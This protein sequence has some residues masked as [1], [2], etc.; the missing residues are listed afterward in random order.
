MIK[1]ICLVAGI[2]LGGVKWVRH[3]DWPNPSEDRG[4]TAVVL[5]RRIVMTPHSDHS[6]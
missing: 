1:K 5:G 6:H 3:K 4:C 2:Y